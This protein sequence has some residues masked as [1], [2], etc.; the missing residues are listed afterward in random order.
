M[1]EDDYHDDCHTLPVAEVYRGCE[2]YGLQSAERIA[3]AK[4]ELGRVVNMTGPRKLYEF[5]GDPRNA[6]EARCLARKKALISIEQRQKVTF[7]R[8]RLEACTVGIDRRTSVMGRLLGLIDAERAGAP[9]PKTWEPPF[10]A[11][12]R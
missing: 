5:A 1:A 6:P 9:W 12:D 4:R 10:T 7:D 11:A 8:E 2:I 3:A